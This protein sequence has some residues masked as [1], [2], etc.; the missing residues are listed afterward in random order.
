MTRRTLSLAAV[1]LLLAMSATAEASLEHVELHI[2]CD[3]TETVIAASPEDA[4]ALIEEMTGVNNV[5]EFG[6]PASERWRKLDDVKHLTM[7]WEGDDLVG[8]HFRAGEHDRP[9]WVSDTAR[10]ITKTRAEWC[11]ELGRSYLGSTEC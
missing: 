7:W 1:A 11:E 8:F 3:D 10:P 4:D 6:E 9:A 2:W 5:E